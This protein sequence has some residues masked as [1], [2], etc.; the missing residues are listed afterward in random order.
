MADDAAPDPIGPWTVKGMPPEDRAEINKAAKRADL[1]VGEWLKSAARLAI[2]AERNGM[3]ASTPGEA[4]GPPPAYGPLL[5]VEIAERAAALLPRLTPEAGGNARL[6]G[7]AR[8][9][10]EQHLRAL[11]LDAAGPPDGHPRIAGR[12]GQGQS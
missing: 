6:A 5:S 10:V 9:V 4:P 1:T 8:K 7:L 2:Q 12:K 3:P 11:L